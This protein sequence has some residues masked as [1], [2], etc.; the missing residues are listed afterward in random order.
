MNRDDIRKIAAQ[1][2]GDPSSGTVADA[3]DVI[4][5][6]IADALNPKPKTEKR[7]VTPDEVRDA[8]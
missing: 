7:V 3:L 2:V 6:A 1:A 4:A 8:Q 5:D